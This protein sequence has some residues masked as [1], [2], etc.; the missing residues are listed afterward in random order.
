MSWGNKLLIAFVA[1]GVLIGTLVYKC[2]HQNFEL[3][4]GD[5]YADELKY[6]DR[7]D[8][9]NNAGKLSPVQVSTA[10]N[11]LAIQLPKELNGQVLKG[12]AWF[13]CA[14]NA[15]DDRRIP[16]AVNEN[17]T[18]LVE[19]NKLAKANYVLK[20]NW[21]NTDEKFYNEQAVSLR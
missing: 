18:M 5:Y 12:E 20:L 14:T 4:S 15:A 17:G 21:E 16:L 6:Q 1:F 13:Y 3:V 8:G 7:I 19:K 11:E 2:M 9:F 10:G